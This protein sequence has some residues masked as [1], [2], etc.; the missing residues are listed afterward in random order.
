MDFRLSVSIYVNTGP[1]E[2]LG[3]VARAMALSHFVP[4]LKN[5]YIVTIRMGI[6]DMATICIGG[7]R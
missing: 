1:K 2:P 7:L 4:N 3:Q 5:T 6:D